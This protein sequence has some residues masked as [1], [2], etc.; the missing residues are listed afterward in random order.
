MGQPIIFALK[1]NIK[2]SQGQSEHTSYRVYT[3]QVKGRGKTWR[4]QTFHN[5]GSGLDVGGKTKMERDGTVLIEEV[6]E[7]LEVEIIGYT[8][9]M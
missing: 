2:K 8:I 5:S 7:G 4:Q 3:V 9:T 6:P 1:L